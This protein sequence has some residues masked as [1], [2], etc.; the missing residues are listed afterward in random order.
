MLRHC[1]QHA[2]DGGSD[3]TGF[4]EAGSKR[5]IPAVAASAI[6]VAHIEERREHGEENIAAKGWTDFS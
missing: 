2:D 6:S 5:E 3:A 4:A 1:R